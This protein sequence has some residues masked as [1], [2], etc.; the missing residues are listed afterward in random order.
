MAQ[1]RRRRIQPTGGSPM[2]EDF[3][4]ER[5]LIVVA[6]REVGLRATRESVAS[7]TGADVSSLADLLASEGVTLRPLFGVSEERLQA[8][9]ASLAAETGA[10]VPDL[11]VYYRVDAPDE[12]LDELAERLR[13]SEVVETAYVKPPAELPQLLNDM[14]PLPAE[15]PV[16]TPD[17]SAR[18]GYLDAAP[19]GIDARYAWTQSGGGGTGVRIIDIEGAWRF[20]HEDLLQNQGGVVGGTQS[21]DI[22]WRNHGTAV[23]GEF[24][25]DRTAFGITG[26]VRTPMCAPSP[27]LVARA[28]R[29]RFA[30]QPICSI[31]ATLSSSN[32]IVQVRDSTLQVALTKEVTSP[33]NGG[34]TTLMRF[35]TPAA[36]A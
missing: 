12:R 26:S 20:T 21:T 8:E 23:V 9:A 36:A 35:A 15:P 30:K 22:G 27:S 18:Q 4:P 25:G 13:Q 16:H 32:S 17:F 14:V 2:P 7:L 33:L 29:E 19:G 11:S 10:E 1:P 24:G 6:K 31:Q 34:Q 3:P 5:E 28:Q